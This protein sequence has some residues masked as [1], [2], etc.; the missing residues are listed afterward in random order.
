MP[1]DQRILLNDR[2]TAP[3]ASANHASTPSPS[4]DLGHRATPAFD[5]ETS[6]KR[7]ETTLKWLETRLKRLEIN[8]ETLKR[9]NQLKNSTS[10]Y[11]RL[12]EITPLKR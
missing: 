5:P 12:T 2:R 7:L 4:H 10:I 1:N 11:Q 8:V 9:F 6:L 3:T